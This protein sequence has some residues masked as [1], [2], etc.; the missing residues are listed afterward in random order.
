M[1]G[2]ASGA[3]P[4]HA[5]FSAL[6]ILLLGDPHLL[7]SALRWEERHNG[8]QG[9]LHPQ[10]CFPLP[11]IQARILFPFSGFLPSC[12]LPYPQPLLNL[13]GENP[14]LGRP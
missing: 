13:P 10:P 3:L 8:G 2:A 11:S 4:F 6:F 5:L 9:T 1:E 14:A 7:E 12:P